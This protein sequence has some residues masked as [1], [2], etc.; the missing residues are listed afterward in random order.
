M[1][2]GSDSGPREVCREGE[3]AVYWDGWSGNR[4]R[5]NMGNTHSVGPA[6]LPQPFLARSRVW[7]TAGVL[8]LVLF[9]WS[10]VASGQQDE[11]QAAARRLAIPDTVLA[12]E[13]MEIR[14]DLQVESKDTFGVFHD[15]RF[16]DRVEE[17]GIEFLHRIVDDSGKHWKPV[18]YDHGNGIAAADVDGDGLEDNLFPYPDRSQSTLEKPGARPVPGPDRSGWS[19]LGRQDQCDGLLRR[20][21]QRRRPP[22]SSSPPCVRETSCSKTRGKA[23][24]GT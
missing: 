21:R 23:G 12:P 17:S 13:W 6:I 11:A 2:E 19:R 16:S 15:F 22:T 20:R 8:A 18:H 14:K 5:G 1:N 7:M 24:S 4:T 10:P 3:S 9:G